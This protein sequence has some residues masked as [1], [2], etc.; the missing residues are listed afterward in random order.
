MLVFDFNNCFIK[1]IAM[2]RDDYMKHKVIIDKG[3]YVIWYM[4]ICDVKYHIYRAGK[5][6]SNTQTPYPFS[7]MFS[8]PVLLD[9]KQ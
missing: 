8:I 2:V 5:R 4:G 1:C 3:C 9:I 6:L 7:P